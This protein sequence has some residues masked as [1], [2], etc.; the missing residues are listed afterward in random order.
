MKVRA[1]W[2]IARSVLIEAVRRKEIYAIVLVSCGLIALTMSL[3]FFQLSGLDKFYREVALK[4][5]SIATALTC[6][7]LAT[8]QLPREFEMR[9]IY[10]LLARPISRLTFLMG[11][12]AGVVLASAFCFGLFMTIFLLGTW[13]L[14]GAIHWGLFGQ[15]L[16]LQMVMIVLLASLSFLLSMLLNLDAAICVGVLF[17]AIA[18]TYTSMLTYLYEFATSAGRV[19]LLVLN[20]GIPQVSLFDLSSKAVHAEVW[21]PLGWGVMGALTLYG[22]IFSAAYA[23]AATLLFRRRAL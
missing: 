1:I 14:G 5:M 9:T 7:V 10:P 16:Y 15:Y 2:L 20:Y 19:G 17:F 21:T 23:G 8:R 11:K 13:R 12:L 6:I 4:T 22:L 18:S 3:D